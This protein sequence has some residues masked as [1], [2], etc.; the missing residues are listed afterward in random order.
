MSIIVIIKFLNV[1]ITNS[2]ILLHN[3]SFFDRVPGQIVTVIPLL[4]LLRVALIAAACS[5]SPHSLGHRSHPVRRRY[6][7]HPSTNSSKLLSFVQSLTY[8]N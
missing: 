2:I 5:A 3:V 7:Y 6:S 4:L 8:H 1:G